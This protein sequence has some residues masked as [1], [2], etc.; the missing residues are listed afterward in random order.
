MSRIS[1]SVSLVMLTVVPAGSARSWPSAKLAPRAG[2]PGSACGAPRVPA[3]ET[4]LPGVPRL[5]TI[6]ATAPAVWALATL[7]PN[8]QVPRCIRATAPL[9]A[10]GKSAASHPLVDVSVGVGWCRPGRPS[11]R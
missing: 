3:T 8:G 10:A 2:I 7:S 9:T 1:D 4:S 11:R 6:A 5:K